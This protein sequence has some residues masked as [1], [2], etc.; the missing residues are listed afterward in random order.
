M[1]QLIPDSHRDLLADEMRAMAFLATV[2]AD[3]TPQVTPVWFDMDGDHIRI[4]TASGRVKDRNMRERPHVA[5]AVVDPEN[6]YRHVQI[7]GKVVAA[8][9]EGAREHIDQLAAKYT[10]REIFP[11][12]EGQIRVIFRI[13]PIS[14]STME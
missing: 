5:L 4:N 14:V 6:P 7:R 3:G 10:D 1:S 9:E 12:P 8:N 11:V 13:Q 2:M